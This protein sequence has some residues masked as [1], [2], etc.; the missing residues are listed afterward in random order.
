MLFKLSV[1]TDEVSQ[2]LETV[3]RFADRFE[4][5]GVEIRSVWSRNP[6]NLLHQKDDIKRI[7]RKYELDVSAIASPFFKAD[8]DNND[9]YEEHLDILR[10]C[11]QLAQ[12]LDTN[13][14]RGFTFWRKNNLDAYIEKI[15]ERFQKPLEMIESE[16]V[17]L[18]IE[19]EPSTFVG[20]GKELADFLDRLGSKHVKAIW[21]PGNNMW[22]PTG[23]IPYPDGYIYV[24]DKT[25]HVHVKDGVR[26]GSDGKP[27]CIAF[28]D[29][30]VDYLG[31]LRALK[32]DGY[33]AYLSLET[34]WRPK[35]HLSED[36]MARPGG[37]EFS[38]L[39]EYA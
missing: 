30:E 23:E 8:V 24:R 22:D 12:A 15:I 10:N 4:L 35:G 26:R 39:G 2:D 31:Q 25:V 29:G 14:I 9:E 20:N 7:L 6:Q 21:D 5:D 17:I 18:G 19:N 33:R 13:I 1:I 3:A 16:G 11:I 38:R 36:L 32:E 27:Q 28:G 34:H 37:E